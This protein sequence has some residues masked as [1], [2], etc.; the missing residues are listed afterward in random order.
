MGPADME[1]YNANYVGGNIGGGDQTFWQ[2][3][4]RPALRLRSPYSTPVKGIY[5]CS[6]STPPGGGV[7]GMCGYHGARLVLKEMFR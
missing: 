2:L 4:A 7:H 1:E 6:S 3:F 5:V